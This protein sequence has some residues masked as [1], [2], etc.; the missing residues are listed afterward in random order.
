MRSSDAG[1]I[2]AAHN[3]DDTFGNDAAVDGDTVVVGA[4]WDNDMM[5]SDSGSA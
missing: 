4:N 5:G 1:Y 2:F 3:A